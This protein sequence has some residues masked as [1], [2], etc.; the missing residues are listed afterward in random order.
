MTS[1]IISDEMFVTML[2]KQL[3]SKLNVITCSATN[4]KEFKI[5]NNVFLRFYLLIS[6]IRS[7]T[8]FSVKVIGDELCSTVF[9]RSK[10]N[11]FEIHISL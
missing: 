9:M 4:L 1:T 6:L 5:N 10:S 8:L 3:E 11:H 7:I 2:H